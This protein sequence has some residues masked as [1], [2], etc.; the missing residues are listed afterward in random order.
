MQ[1]LIFIALAVV[2]FMLCKY[3]FNKERKVPNR[4]DLLLEFIIIVS[5]VYLIWWILY[6][7]SYLFVFIG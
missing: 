3:S 5:V 7:A 6:L 2:I 4:K 1:S